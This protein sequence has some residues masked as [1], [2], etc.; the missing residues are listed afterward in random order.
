LIVKK[1]RIAVWT[2]A[3]LGLVFGVVVLA[4][5]LPTYRTLARSTQPGELVEGLADLGGR[6]HSRVEGKRAAP[7]YRSL[8][9][10]QPRP[11]DAAE[12]ED[13]VAWMRSLDHDELLRLTNAEYDFEESELIQRL[14]ALRGP[15]VLS[16][17]GDLAVAENDPLIRAVL[18]EGLVGT[19]VDERLGDERL[20]P[21]LDALMTRMGHAADDPYQVAN[22]L[23]TYAYVA[24]AKGQQDYVALMGAHLLGSDNRALLTHGYLFMG[25]FEGAEA[26][27]EQVLSSHPSPEGRFGAVEG[28]R[29]AA[30]QGRIP[31]AEITALGLNAL[32]AESNDRNRLLIYEMMI[33]TGGEE[34]LGAVEQLLRAGKTSEVEET[35]EMLA[36]K[37]EPNRAQALFEDLLRDQAL[38]GEAK[39]AVYNAMGLLPGEEGSEFLLGLA[40]NADL[41]DD[42]RLAGLRALWNRPL[43]ERLAGEL[44][45]L[46]DT[47]GGAG[48]R[49][50]ALRILAQGERGESIDLR[51]V[52]ALDED[53]AVRAEA[54]Q[55]AAMQPSEN[56]RAWLEER[57]LQDDSIDVKAAA[58]G[59]LVYH[60]HYTGDGDAVLGYLD[61]ARRF[62]NDETALAMI[63]DG[64]RMVKDYD[65][66]DLD[67]G[68]AQEAEFWGTVAKY[69]DGPA[70]RSFERQAK[71]LAQ[72]VTTLRSSRDGRRSAR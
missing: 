67:L 54:V 14:Q 3:V 60:A 32:E 70:A 16:A 59:A 69:T 49:T 22:G 6:G 53:P 36:M 52:A 26:V 42:E 38:E 33:S 15:W 41:G 66:R 21:L 47:A 1:H 39:Q 37:M 25:R 20:L 7:E 34:A 2:M 13:L 63:A 23:A 19:L 24:C 43:D 11:T 30:T 58:L 62:T 72:I 45:S 8:P 27:L 44:R 29:A 56:N 5:N 12:L 4:R 46:F 51:R 9:P 35:A 31:P 61:R 64:E 40:K 57:L 48:V 17:L 10:D 28:L 65:P 50:E 71:Q 55:L 68:L 18:V